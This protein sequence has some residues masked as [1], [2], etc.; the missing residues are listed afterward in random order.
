M[1]MDSLLDIGI[2][3]TIF[4]ASS[5]F[6]SKLGSDLRRE[7][8]EKGKDLWTLHPVLKDTLLEF[9]YRETIPAVNEIVEFYDRARDSKK[10]LNLGDLMRIPQHL[11]KIND[12][13]KRLREEPQNGKDDS[14]V[15]IV[16]ETIEYF[17]W[18]R[19]ENRRLKLED[20]PH[21]P[22]NIEE[23]ENRLRE[24]KKAFQEEEKIREVHQDHIDYCDYAGW[25]LIIA[26]SFSFI[27]IF[28]VGIIPIYYSISSLFLWIVDLGVFTFLIGF[29]AMKYR[30]SRKLEKDFL[31]YRMEYGRSRTY[32]QELRG[33]K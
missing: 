23:L 10:D 14:A 27:S 5:V 7:A 32:Y 9:N 6:F 12:Q 1:A 31:D 11:D 25:L 20:V 28:I 33:G 13:I 29:A 30:K 16:I 17:D 22:S 24:L 8:R 18:I 4:V 2:I 15:S 21:N 19:S 26:A 3:S